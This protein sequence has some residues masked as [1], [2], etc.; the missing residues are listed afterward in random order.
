MEKNE[1]Q[2]EIEIKNKDSQ[3]LIKGKMFEKK[4]DIKNATKEKKEIN[5]NRQR[6]KKKR[7]SINIDKEKR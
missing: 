4:T 5:F 3:K 7:E 2:K 1:K 6:K